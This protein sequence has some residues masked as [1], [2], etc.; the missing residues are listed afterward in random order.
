LIS[1]SVFLA[2]IFGAYVSFNQKSPAI[3]INASATEVLQKQYRHEVVWAIQAPAT[4]P[5]A[6]PS[7]G[8]RE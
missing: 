6:G 5:I 8:A 2:R 4:G 7:K 1:L 3:W